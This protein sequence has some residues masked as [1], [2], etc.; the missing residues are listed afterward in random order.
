MHV[1]VFF[2]GGDNFKGGDKDFGFDGM[3]TL[4][5]ILQYTKSGVN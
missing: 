1:E 2:G 5:W 4:K 3:L